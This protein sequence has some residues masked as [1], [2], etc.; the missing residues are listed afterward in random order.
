MPYDI[1]VPPSEKSSN[2]K[3]S[4][5]KTGGK[6]ILHTPLSGDRSDTEYIQEALDMTKELYKPFFLGLGEAYDRI[7]GGK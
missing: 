4:V 6:Y 1:T 2:R 3:K 7:F 5:T